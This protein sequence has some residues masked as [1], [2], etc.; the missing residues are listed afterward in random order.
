MPAKP[1]DEIDYLIQHNQ[2]SRLCIERKERKIL[3]KEFQ[4]HQDLRNLNYHQYM[5]LKLLRDTCEK[6][7]VGEN[8]TAELSR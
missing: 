3:H 6:G 8:Q 2:N 7:S 5:E 1:E 4:V